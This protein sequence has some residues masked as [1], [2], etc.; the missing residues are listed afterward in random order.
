MANASAKKSWI[1]RHLIKTLVI[2]LGV[3]GIACVGFLAWTSHMLLRNPLCDEWKSGMDRNEK[4][5]LAL[6]VVNDSYQAAFVVGERDDGSPILNPGT[7]IPYPNTDIILSHYPDCCGLYSRHTAKTENP[8]EDISRDDEG[9]VVM[10][11]PGNFRDNSGEVRT[12][13]IL[14][15]ADFNSC[16]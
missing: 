13:P 16:G 10:R 5:H 9:I 15:Y 1:R 8:S 6:Q 11:Y 12:A 14:M 4:I 7:Q 2:I 3:S